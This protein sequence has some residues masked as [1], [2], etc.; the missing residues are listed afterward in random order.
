MGDRLATT[1]MGRKFGGCAPPPFWGAVYVPSKHNVAWNLDPSGRLAT[2]DMSRK[3]GS[4][5]PFSW[6]KLHCKIDFVPT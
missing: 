2:V 6:V 5:P 3:L 4:V 1:D